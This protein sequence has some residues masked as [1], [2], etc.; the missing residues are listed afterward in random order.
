MIR[1]W[2][3]EAPA[4]DLETLALQTKQALWLEDRRNNALARLLGAK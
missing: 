3:G 4:D 1:H 2:L